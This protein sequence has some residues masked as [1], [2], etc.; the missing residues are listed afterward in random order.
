MEWRYALEGGGS[1]TVEEAG[2][3]A[4]L[5]AERPE[6]GRGLYKAYLRGPAGRALLG[7]LAPEGG[8]LRVRRTLTLDDLKRQGA[9]PPVGGEV[10]LAFAF[11]RD[12]APA[13]WR[14]TDPGALSFGE[15]ALRAMAVRQGKVLLRAEGGGFLLA[16]PFSCARPFPMP[17][18]FCLARPVRLEGE[19]Y[20]C[21][22]FGRDGW[23]MPPGRGGGA[24]V[25]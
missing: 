5:T 17:A 13:G 1:L 6:D 15:E 21:F 11:D 10:E 4:V 22:R 3:R 12:R 24:A 2:L 25:C 19:S 9:W 8:R 23:P 18:L 14:W 20:V 7:T 16:C